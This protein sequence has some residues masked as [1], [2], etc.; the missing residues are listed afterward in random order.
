MSTN[1]LCIQSIIEHKANLNCKQFTG[2]TPLH[3]AVQKDLPEVVALLLENG[4]V[5][6]CV[7]ENGISPLFLAA[8]F[9]RAQC[10]EL[11]LNALDPR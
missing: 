3:Y 4:A 9:G 11:L 8:Q 2:S 6:E 5:S 10:L 1:I 7:D